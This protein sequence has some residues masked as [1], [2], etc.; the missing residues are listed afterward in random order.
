MIFF[1]QRFCKEFN[2]NS[3]IQQK[4]NFIKPN[5]HSNVF[6]KDL[7]HLNL[8]KKIYL[9]LGFIPKEDEFLSTQI[10]PFF[11]LG[12]VHELP[13]AMF[14]LNACKPH[15]GNI[16]PVCQTWN[17][18]SHFD[19]EYHFPVSLYKHPQVVL[20][21]FSHDRYENDLL[22]IPSMQSIA[23]RF[24]PN[25]TRSQN[26]H[27][28]DNMFIQT[29]GYNMNDEDIVQ[30][31]LWGE[32]HEHGI[33]MF[34][35][36][37]VGSDQGFRK[38]FHE[39]KTL[40][41]IHSRHVLLPY[42]HSIP[43]FLNNFSNYM[44]LKHMRPNFVFFMAGFRGNAKSLREEIVSAVQE[45]PNSLYVDMTKY[46][47]FES[48]LKYT[49]M[50]TKSVFC[51]CP[52]GDSDDTRRIFTSILG[53]CIPIIFADYIV[54]P[55]EGILDWMQ[56]SII[57]PQS[58]AR[59]FILELPNFSQSRITELQEGLRIVRH[60]FVFHENGS[61]P[62]DATDLIMTT[63]ASRARIMKDFRRWTKQLHSNFLDQL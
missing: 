20:V 32:D 44:N 10:F 60:H 49:S 55:F 45:L 31:D 48:N 18:E 52:R 11:K 47:I 59:K 63:L 33:K 2:L 35:H 9:P 58:H 15:D 29:A 5:L 27:H 22:Y 41:A 16:N 38:D 40:F 28:D 53:G 61:L 62:G 8:L 1:N 34:F 56:F 42:T 21:N 7:F 3:K 19:V 17:M 50:V 13:S 6:Y 25:K 26:L 12:F 46:G 43:L 37:N 39:Q 14:W 24:D 51:P 54:L 36:G 4:T 30:I 57:V 23:L